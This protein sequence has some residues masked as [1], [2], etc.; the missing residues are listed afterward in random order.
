MS[1]YFYQER[2][3]SVST[4]PSPDAYMVPFLTYAGA[5]AYGSVISTVFGGLYCILERDAMNSEK[6]NAR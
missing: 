6:D 4:I 1:F 2:D 5:R 3:G